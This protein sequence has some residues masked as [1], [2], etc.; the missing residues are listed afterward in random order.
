MQTLTRI[1]GGMAVALATALIL[2]ACGGGGSGGGSPTAQPMEPDAPTV[3]PEPDPIASFT[4][5]NQTGQDLLDHWNQHDAAQSALGLTTA[6]VAMGAIRSLMRGVDDIDEPSRAVMRN[7]GGSRIKTIGHDNGITY[8]T[9]QDGPAGTL[10]MQLDWSQAGSLSAER[11]GDFERAVK[12]WTYRLDE[13]FPART[14]PAH[15]DYTFMLFEYDEPQIADDVLVAVE[16]QTWNGSEQAG[17][18]YFEWSERNGDLETWFGH[19][20]IPPA[21]LAFYNTDFDRYIYVLTHELGHVL[22]SM[23]LVDNAG[24]F[25]DMGPYEQYFDA[26]NGTFNGPNAMAANG[27]N[28]V[29]YQWIGEDFYPVAPGTPGARIDFG[30][31]GPC[32]SIMSYCDNPDGNP[33]VKPS[34]LDFAILQDLGYDLLSAREA[35]EPEVY[36]YGAWA[37]YGAWGAGVERIITY[38]GEGDNLRITDRLS[39]HADAFGMAPGTEFATAYAGMTGS[40]TWEGSLLGVDIRQAMLPPVFG[41]AAMTVD[42]A[43]LDGTVAFSNLM[44]AV[45]GNVRGFRQ[46]DLEYDVTVTG[47]G[48]ADAN[49]VIDGAFYGPGHDEMAGIVDDRSSSVGLIGGFGGVR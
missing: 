48:F 37:T 41:D 39:A 10:N 2:A 43:D 19:I 22:P 28:P 16:L 3:M 23:P 17:G 7:A 42:L 45:D 4:R 12:A 32:D 47:N 26:E 38:H 31:I 30:H 8:G 13:D 29:P 44:T 33:N 24:L 49:G 6:N 11:R 5:D 14:V 25:P 9:W 40:A 18:N 35:S 15:E 34:E 46:S 20:Q 27:G 1:L 36:G 21:R